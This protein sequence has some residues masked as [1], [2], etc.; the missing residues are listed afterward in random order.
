MYAWMLVLFRASA[1]MFTVPV[2]DHAGLP[3]TAKV[4]FAGLLAWIALP[5]AGTFAVPPNV[6]AL[7]LVAGKEI[8]IGVMMGMAVRLIFAALDLAARILAVEIGM[9]P[10]PEF[11]STNNVAG[12]PIGTAIYYLGIVV[13][14]S[15]AHY[16]VIVAFVRS[17]ELVPPGLQ[18]A[19]TGFVGE[20]VKHTSRLI[21]L[22]VL[23]SAPFMAINFLVNLT[24]SLLGRVVPRMNVFV[25]SFSVRII[26][27]L[28]LL[29]VSGGLI[30]HYIVREFE[31]APETMLR[32]LPFALR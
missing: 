16:A 30:S 23:I 19:D 10:P 29:A 31:A 3:R 17:L 12:N 26:A 14:L 4:A 27:G 8:A 20:F 7:A 24:F 1:L 13:F 32:F 25:L 11:S 9:H 18:A 6:L 28:A 2:F 22:G 21:M 15:G 5:Q